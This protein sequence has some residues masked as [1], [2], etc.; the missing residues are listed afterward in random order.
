MVR[1]VVPVLATAIR[2]LRPS[3]S[4]LKSVLAELTQL[5]H[6]IGTKL[7]LA[8]LQARLN[9]PPEGTRCEAG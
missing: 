7:K 5:K 1:Q 8:D 6:K 2:P 9:Q 4:E 3:E